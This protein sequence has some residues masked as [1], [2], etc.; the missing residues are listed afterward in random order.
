MDVVFGCGDG[1]LSRELSGLGLV[2]TLYLGDEPVCDDLPGYRIRSAADV[3]GVVHSLYHGHRGALELIGT[4]FHLNEAWQHRRSELDAIFGQWWG[5][6][7][8]LPFSWGNSTLDGV[9]G[10]VNAIRNAP[11]LLCSPPLENGAYSCP[12]ISIG[13]GPS[14]ADHLP[15][16]RRIQGKAL[17]VSCD[18][19]AGGLLAAGI[20]PDYVTPLERLNSTWQKLPDSCGGAIFAGTPVVPPQTLAAFEGHRTRLITQPDVLYRWMLGEAREDLDLWTGG[21]SGTMATAVALRLTTGPVYLVGHD[22]STG[23]VHHWEGAPVSTD[24]HADD[25]QSLLVRGARKPEVQ[26]KPDW[27]RFAMQLADMAT[28]RTVYHV[29]GEDSVAILGA[30]VVDSLPRLDEERTVR[31]EAVRP[32]NLWDGFRPQLQRLRADLRGLP[33]RAGSITRLEDMRGD[34]LI[35]SPNHQMLEYVLRPLWAQCGVDRRLGRPA[36]D[37]LQMCRE[38]IANFTREMAPEIVAAAEAVL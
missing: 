2:W 34:R 38:R 7:R 27:A 28:D 22:L 25:E 12:A 14:L 31:L 30:Q 37:I 36:T 26:T 19:A 10:V 4:R 29:A 21:S 6:L 5:T 15:A 35:P 8:E 18:A 11:S 16:L 17:I 3:P 20:R 33:E 13:A 23:P 32:V 9:C 24:L 1:S